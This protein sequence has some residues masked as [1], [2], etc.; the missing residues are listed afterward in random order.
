MDGGGGR[1]PLKWQTRTSCTRRAKNVLRK[2]KR[3]RE[4]EI[5]IKSERYK[6]IK[7]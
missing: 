7:I 4:S 5:K 1:G 6:S 2:E 3:E